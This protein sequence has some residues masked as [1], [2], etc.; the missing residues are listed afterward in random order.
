M[1]KKKRSWLLM[2][3]IGILIFSF[4]IPCVTHA[5]I[6]DVRQN[7]PLH[8]QGENGIFLQYRDGP[9]Y[10]NLIN[11]NPFIPDYTNNAAVFVNPDVTD[12][13]RFPAV[14]GYEYN[15]FPVVSSNQISAAPS[16][17]PRSNINADAVVRIIIP[18]NGGNVRI[19]GSCGVTPNTPNPPIGD[20]Y[21]SIYKGEGNYNSPLWSASKSGAIDIEIRYSK[22][23]E[24]LFA[25]NRGTDACLGN[26]LAYWKDLKLITP[27]YPVPEFPSLSLPAI[28]II[29]FL[30]AVLLIQRTREL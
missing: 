10:V 18:G 23:E 11:Y 8:T 17:I 4:S 20:V 25:T 28:M 21:F 2:Y 1:D 30:G 3:C 26:D 5:Y 15:V 19:T 7:F 9:D 6:F 14:L 16:C 29:G 13:D 24:L 27:D 22:G 12:G